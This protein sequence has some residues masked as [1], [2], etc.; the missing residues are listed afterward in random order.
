V[1]ANSK[2]EW[3]HH[4]FNPW[5][6]CTKVHA[7]C[8]HCYAERDA[9]RFPANRGI[10][11]P[12]GTRVK[13][14]EAMWREPLKWN[15]EAE[16]AGE[17]RRV[18]C[19]SLADVFE[20]WGESIVDQ[21]GD[22]IC[23]PYLEREN[24]AEF[25]TSTSPELLKT[26][27]QGWS[28]I[29]MHDL[30]RELFALIA[31]TPWLDWLLLTKRPENVERMWPVDF[32]D[33]GDDCADEEERQFFAEGS[34]LKHFRNVWLGTSISDQ[35]TADEW[36]PRLNKLAY[37]CPVR[38]LSIEPLIGPV[39]IPPQCLWAGSGV[40][41]VIVGGESGSQARPMHPDWVRSLRNQCQAAG[42]AFFFKQWGEWLPFNSGEFSGIPSWMK[43]NTPVCL[44]KPDGRFIRPYCF[45][46]A[47]GH[48]MARVGKKAAGRLLDG[49]TWD[50]F[51]QTEAAH[52]AFVRRSRR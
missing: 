17:R 38:F 41:W 34:V 48:E 37:L 19:A 26:D 15:R 39:T 45:N 52:D 6:G 27:P 30:R 8:A 36:G 25:W 29:T 4:T 14:S 10:W 22:V 1:A 18:F 24:T 47:P 50:E 16:K 43:D 28:P 3:T 40:Q 13:A 32:I 2:I 23:R 12:N 42:V 5:R 11:G 33:T 35:A 9:K 21:H 46:D 20:D 31:A 51:P 44:V 7:G 49:R